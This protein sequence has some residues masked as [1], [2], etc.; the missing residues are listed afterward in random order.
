MDIEE[1][2]EKSKKY[3]LDEIPITPQEIEQAI[4]LICSA[5]EK[6]VSVG[7]LKSTLDQAGIKVPNLSNTLHIMKRVS[8][9]ESGERGMYRNT[10][11]VQ[12]IATPRVCKKLFDSIRK[13]DLLK[14]EVE[15]RENDIEQLQKKVDRLLLEKRQFQHLSDGV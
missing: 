15:Q 12:I 9:V 13:I 5:Y 7:F 10:K 14:N 4:V 2:I 8:M 6:P 11:T 3:G 1:L